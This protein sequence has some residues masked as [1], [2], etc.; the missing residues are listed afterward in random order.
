VLGIPIATVKSPSASAEPQ[1]SEI[2]GKTLLG[3]LRSHGVELVCLAGYIRKI[4]RE[5]INE[6]PGRIMNIHNALIPS[7]CGKGM[8]GMNVHQAAVDYGVKVSGCTVHFVDEGYD[9]GPIIMQSTVPVYAEDTAEDVS[10]RA[11]ESAKLPTTTTIW[12][13]IRPS[14]QAS[15]I[16]FILLPRP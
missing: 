16:D 15:A 11:G 5:V 13:S 12:P 7:F 14:A 9:T 1:A 2:Y 3:V 6:F 8:Y 10:A 4:P